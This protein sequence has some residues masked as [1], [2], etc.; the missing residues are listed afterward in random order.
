VLLDQ[1][2]CGGVIKVFGGQKKTSILSILLNV[3]VICLVADLRQ[4]LATHV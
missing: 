3:R 2:I 1:L 4:S